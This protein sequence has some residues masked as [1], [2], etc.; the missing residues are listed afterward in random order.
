MT[1]RPVEFDELL[2][3]A[4]VATMFR[5]A[6]HTVTRWARSGKLPYL[7]TL[8]SHRRYRRED[9]ERLLQGGQS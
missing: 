1:R 5:V 4:E 7:L 2:T 8:G 9:V 6:P 3:R